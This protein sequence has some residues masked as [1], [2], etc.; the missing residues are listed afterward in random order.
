[1]KFQPPCPLECGKRII[2]EFAGLPDDF[3]LKQ[4]GDFWEIHH[5][6]KST[7]L[8]NVFFRKAGK[9]WLSPE[10]LPKLP[11]EYANKLEH[12]PNSPFIGR[13]IPIL[14][15]I[16]ERNKG[17]NPPMLPI[18]VIGS[19]Y[20][21]LSRYEEAA[22]PKEDNH[23]RFPANSSIAEKSG[24]LERPLADEYIALLWETLAATWPGLVRPKRES[25]TLVSCDVDIP[26]DRAGT[27][28]YLSIRRGLGKLAR[29]GSPVGF[30]EAAKNYYHTKRG[31]YNHDRCYRGII[32]IMDS[33][34]KAGNQV[35][36]NFIPRPSH[37]KYDASP[38][39][40]T[41]QMRAL[42]Q[43]IHRRGH[44]IGFHPGYGTYDNAAEF[45]KSAD[46]FWKVLEEEDIQQKTY[47]GRQHYLRWKTPLTATFWEQAGFQY[48]STLGFADKPGF[49]CGTCREFP[50]LGLNGSESQPKLLERP[51][52][53]MECSVM[54]N[55]YMGINDPSEAL[56]KMTNL[57]QKCKE[58]GGDFTLLWHN[59]E[60][61]SQSN[62][63]IYNQL[64]M[65]P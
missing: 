54:G 22:N 15:G 62:I 60:L 43:L 14:Y 63:N 36:F 53:L 31:N 26:F 12:P 3:T 32:K 57:K 6:N 55:Q 33:N 21:M 10:S 17:P 30:S 49:R 20:F 42:L 24:I 39:T 51:L 61:D 11:L 65:K 2:Y 47:G 29:N 35:T 40:D 52:I 27:S 18:D 56:A 5:L 44:F 1:M 4:N 7:S 25:R 38:P 41:P 8:P 64:I 9:D 16:Q 48:D 13:D 50:M 34:E 19:V 59:T 58:A 37:P 28:L 23:G 46:L 45:K